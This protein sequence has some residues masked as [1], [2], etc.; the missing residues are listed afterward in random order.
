MNKEIKSREK[1]KR[2]ISKRMV[3]EK[4]NGRTK[5]TSNPR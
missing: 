1:K 3:W 4:K 2:K 5:D